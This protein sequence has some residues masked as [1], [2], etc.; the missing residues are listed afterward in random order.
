MVYT[1][2]YNLPKHTADYYSIQI[3]SKGGGIYLRELQVYLGNCDACVNYQLNYQ[4]DW[5][6][7]YSYNSTTSSGL[8]IYL[9]FNQPVQ[10]NSTDLKTA[11]TF[12]I[13]KLP[14]LKM[15][16]FDFMNELDINN[17][18]HY[19]MPIDSSFLNGSLTVIV[20]PNTTLFGTTHGPVQLY[21][22]RLLLN[23]PLNI[24]QSS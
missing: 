1:F 24:L 13:D 15:D 5:L 3:S 11:F 10:P 7:R 20:A 4:V 21:S 22:R 2:T 23:N 17:R 8:D 16:I 18:L 19:Y 9:Q 12:S 14:D 6:P